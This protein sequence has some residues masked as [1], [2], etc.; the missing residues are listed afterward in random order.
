MRENG[1][2]TEVAIIMEGEWSCYR[3]GHFIGGR[4]VMLRMWSVLWRENGQFTEVLTLMEYVY[5]IV[6]YGEWVV[7]CFLYRYILPLNLLTFLLLFINVFLHTAK[8]LHTGEGE[9]FMPAKIEQVCQSREG[10]MD[11]QCFRPLL[12]T[13]KAELGRG[14]PGLMR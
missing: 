11:E 10:W 14:Q 2:V 7:F 9:D 8:V 12:C 5:F 4:M 1:H 3:S 6:F 13:V